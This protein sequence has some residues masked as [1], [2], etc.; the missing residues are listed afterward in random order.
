MSTYD[1]NQIAAPRQG[2]CAPP[3]SAATAGRARFNKD[4]CGAVCANSEKALREA[5]LQTSFDGI[6]IYDPRGEVVFVNGSFA[7]VG[8]HEDPSELIGKNWKAFYD[9][10]TRD[11]F[12]KV[13]IPQVTASGRWRGEVPARRADG[14]PYHQEVSLAR[15]ED[16]RTAQAIRDISGRKEVEAELGRARDAAVEAAR[17]KAE[18]LANMSHE[19]R[20]PLSGV[21]GM[22]DLLLDSG[23][24][25]Q[26][27]EFAEALSG[28]AH[29][30]LHL[31]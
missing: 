17:V 26:Q 3:A 18:F 16:G 22:A 23:L 21:I 5:V 20:T 15:L 8:G 4:A 13:I 11:L 12:R 7:A 10:W 6:A 14:T 24:T 19:I 27:R 2:T 25:G 30:L 9:E 28:S 31:I 29:T 1:T